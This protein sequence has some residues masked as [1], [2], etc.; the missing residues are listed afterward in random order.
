MAGGNR[1]KYPKATPATNAKRIPGIDTYKYR[2]SLDVNPGD[3]NITNWYT[4]KGKASIRPP[5][6]D[7][8]IDIPNIS[9]AR[10]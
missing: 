2:F 5:N 6:N 4:N 9:V 1:I 3:T 7:I 8:F 10:V